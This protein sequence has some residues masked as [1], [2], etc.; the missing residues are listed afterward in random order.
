MSD[1]Q[2]PIDKIEQER[3]L[4]EMGMAGFQVYKGARGMGA[5]RYEAIRV[6]AAWFLS[7]VLSAEQHQEQIEGDD[8]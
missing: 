1:E 7:L 5:S 4:E 6:T 8:D 3:T 2:N